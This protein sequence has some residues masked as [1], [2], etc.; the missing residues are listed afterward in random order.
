[1]IAVKDFLDL[2]IYPNLNKADAVKGLDPEDRGTYFLVTCPECG[3]RDAHISKTGLY[4]KCHRVHKCGHFQS[5]WD[6]IQS[7]KGLTN[8]G[9]VRELARLAGRTL[10]ELI[11]PYDKLNYSANGDILE[12]ALNF[13][14]AQLW[15]NKADDVLEY[16][17]KTGFTDDEIRTL[18]LGYYS[19]QAETEA[20]LVDKGYFINA[21]YSMGFK[22]SGFGETHK[23]VVPFRDP[24][25]H[26]LGFIA[27]SAGSTVPQYVFSSGISAKALFNLNPISRDDRLVLVK[28]FLFA[29]MAK[30]RG[31]ESI[32]A[33]GC[34]HL[35][36]EQL[37]LAVQ[38][39]AKR[40]VFAVEEKD[41]AGDPVK[42]SLDLVRHHGYDAFV[43]VIPDSLRDFGD[44]FSQ[45]GVKAFRKAIS[46]AQPAAEW[47]GKS[48]K[49]GSRNNRKEVLQG[50]GLSD[51]VFSASSTD[52]LQNS[53]LSPEEVN[54]AAY[55]AHHEIFS[56][57]S[58]NVNVSSRDRIKGVFDKQNRPKPP[59]LET[60]C[61]SSLCRDL[62]EEQE[63][64]RTGYRS[65]DSVISIP[66]SALTIIAGRPSHG[67]TT[68]MTNLTLS[69][70][71]LYTGKAFL[72]FSY[73]ECRRDVGLRFLNTICGEIL[74]DSDNLGG[75]GNYLAENDTGIPGIEEGKREFTE[76][77]EGKRLWITDT[78]YELEDL[79]QTIT[80][81]AETFEVGA[82]FIDYLQRLKM[83]GSYSTREAELLDITS[84]LART[85]RSLSVPI[86][87]G[88]RIGIQGDRK[89]ESKER[90][91]RLGN[92]LDVDSDAHLIIGLWNESVRK[93]KETGK[94]SRTR[95]TD[96]E[97]LILKN[98]NGPANNEITL[99]LDRPVLRM[100]DKKRVTHIAGVV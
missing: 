90:V 58:E 4:I 35:T 74:D 75:L 83:R 89:A 94:T 36:E 8:E 88:M 21:V 92:L 20:F 43:S 79:V 56:F 13:F 57:F 95:T 97:L 3:Q 34:D 23:L 60:Y 11:G 66:Q 49:S 78:P 51:A 86:I 9:T 32:A 2:E 84:E 81:M 1:M 5:L 72:F 93:E 14:K 71:K 26:L 68:F 73:A 53:G 55:D 41:A 42:E 99:S 91:I 63:S 7:T 24:A 12:T 76:L 98:K 45:T 38:Y 37:A 59:E 96:L 17:R 44:L 70:V 64:I 48:G 31:V 85:A 30:I 6:Y 69:M 87:L 25:G 10:P 47:K 50:S 15:T 65:L 80:K 27:G 77:T 18:E 39:G 61:L 52:F 22:T 28:D 67:M 29:F 100:K 46:S 40:F 54:S 16:L 62:S 33:W 19:S 82:V